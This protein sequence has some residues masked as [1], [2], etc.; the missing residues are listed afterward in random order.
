MVITDLETT[1]LKEKKHDIIQIA[2]EVIDLDTHERIP[3]LTWDSYIYLEAPQ[4]ANRDRDAMDVNKISKD[5]LDVLGM[6][7]KDA[8]REFSIGVNWSE[9]VLTAWGNDFE[10]KFLDEAYTK[11]NRIIPY[12]FKTFDVRSANFQEQLRQRPYDIEYRGLKDAAL[13]WHIPVEEQKMHTAV[14]DV[15]LTSEIFIHNIN[16]GV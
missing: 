1:G 9:A 6:P 8:L 11:S 5:L 2:R 16:F 12:L 15:W 3:Q 14:Y 4:W 10:L 13:Y 7:L